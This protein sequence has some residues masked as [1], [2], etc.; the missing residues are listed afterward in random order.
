MTN[1]DVSKEE[2]RVISTFVECLSTCASSY[3]CMRVHMYVVYMYVYVCI[4]CR[5]VKI[6]I[7]AVPSIGDV[8]KCIISAIA[9]KET[10]TIHLLTPVPQGSVSTNK[11]PTMHVEGKKTHVMVM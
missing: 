8:F 9:S 7:G 4:R 1:N 6:T 2:Q 11:L 10:G 3:L 5:V